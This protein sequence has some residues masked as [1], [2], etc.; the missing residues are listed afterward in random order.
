MRMPV[1][2]TYRSACCLSVVFLNLFS[3]LL[4][5]ADEATADSEKSKAEQ[6]VG[7][8][9]FWQSE[10]QPFLEK[11]CYDC[12]SGEGAEA[13]VDFEIY[14]AESNLSEQRPRWNQVRGM[15]EIGAMPP[16][17]YDSQPDRAQREKIAGWINRQINKV[18]CEI[19]NDA[20][21]VTIRR[22]NNVEYDNTLRDL[23]NI[24][25][26]PSHL[27]GFPSDGVGNGF[28]NQGDVLTLA[29]L[30]LEKYLQAAEYVSSRVIVDDIESLREQESVGEKIFVGEVATRKFLFAD[31]KYKIG[32]RMEYG[33][34]KKESVPVAILV[35]GEEIGQ[36]EALGRNLVRQVAFEATAGEHAIGVKFLDDPHSENKRDYRR[37]LEIDYIRMI[38]PADGLPR[39]PDSHRQLFVATPDDETSVEEAAEQIFRPFIRRA[40]RR[41]PTEKDMSR[42]V[43]LVTMAT[44]E[45]E[46]FERAIGYGLQ[47]VLVSPHFLFRGE[48]P[49]SRAEPIKSGSESG[50]TERISQFALATRLSYFLWA[51]CPDDALLDLATA[52]KLHDPRVLQAEAERM[53]A[54]SRASMLVERFF[55]QAFGL[56]NLKDADP[57][58]DMFPLW[59]DR[60]RDAMLQETHLFCREI[61]KEDMPLGTLITGDFTFVNPRLAELYG[62]EFDG[63]DPKQLYLG[64]P[65]FSRDRKKNSREADYA[66]EDKWIRVQL[67]EGRRGILTQAAVLTL[68]SNPTS[69]SPVKRGK[70]ILENIFGDPPPPAPPNVP[71]FEATQS[72]H[73]NLSLREQLA[74]HRE[75]P[76]CASCHNVMDPLGLGFEHFDAIGQWRDK[77]GEHEIDAAGKLANGQQFDGSADLV[78]LIE[79]RLP[80]VSRHFANKLLTYA[81]G[82]GLEPYD[83]CAVDEIVKQ[84]TEDDYRV[85][86][87]VKAVVTSQPFTRRR[88]QVEE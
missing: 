23:L 60:L 87:F 65:G 69:T 74:I 27:I 86:A 4:L 73:E 41:T 75:N 44:R 20:G 3:A 68:T 62:I 48:S 76:S 55:G 15:I 22:L 84:V 47:S 30:Q 21:R 7:D 63:S 61:L 32:V 38:G 81:L 36:V 45:G 19:I 29:P 17:D 66:S 14:S 37:R 88:I 77:D 25:F 58:G 79:K 1:R 51:S 54:D 40:F 56:G 64:G 59:N 8:E 70:W 6:P 10:L 72:E 9:K 33:G 50:G 12:H 16:A 78:R 85:S 57:S 26:K 24:D 83:Y 43:N 11:Y 39:L 46:S 5:K 13:D 35:D 31:G 82:R 2:H 80:E 53:L 52:G 28:D 71:N 49:P 18:D 67:P 42:V 34:E